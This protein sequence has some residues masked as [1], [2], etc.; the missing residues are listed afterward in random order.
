VIAAVIAIAFLAR[1]FFANNDKK[2]Q[3]ELM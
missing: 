3:E 1:Y 2:D